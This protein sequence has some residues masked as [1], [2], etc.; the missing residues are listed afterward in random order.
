MKFIK[1]VINIFKLYEWIFVLASLILLV[2]LSIVYN[3][4]WLEIISV[5]FG[6]VSAA[7]NCKR[8][9][10][11]FFVYAIYVILYGT[12][13]FIQVQYGEGIL[14]TCINLPIYLYTIYKYYIKDK[15]FKKKNNN[16]NKDE[17]SRDSS[18]FK[19]NKLTKLMVILIVIFVPLITGVYGYI[20]SLLNSNLPYL[21]AMATSFAIVAVFLTSAGITWQWLF[22]TFY[23]STNA[24]IWSLNFMSPESSNSG[25]LYIVLNCVYIVINTYSLITWIKAE[26]QQKLIS[27]NTNTD[28]NN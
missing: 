2:T 14:N 6:L 5:I 13:A 22:W 4:W 16:E 28:K 19:I 3:S 21:N 10:Y 18:D 15:I 20:L 26:K 8:K 23:S 11:A 17:N 12:F 25:I 1:K 7:L 9:K 27:Q 24:V